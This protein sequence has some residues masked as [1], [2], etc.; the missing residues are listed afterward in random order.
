M[1]G[2]GIPFGT[3]VRDLATDR[4][5]VL[6]DVTYLLDAPAQLLAFLRPVGGGREWVTLPDMIRAE[7]E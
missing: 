1:T 4:V 7:T 6:Q 5:G 2:D 3:L